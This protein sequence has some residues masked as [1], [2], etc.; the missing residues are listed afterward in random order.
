MNKNAYNTLKDLLG[1]ECG[2]GSDIIN[3]HAEN[4]DSTDLHTTAINI[5]SFEDISDEWKCRTTNLK[6]ASNNSQKTTFSI[7]YA[8]Q[9]AI[10]FDDEI[11]LNTLLNR[12]KITGKSNIH[13]KSLIKTA[14]KKKSWKCAASLYQSNEKQLLNDI[15]SCRDQCDESS[16]GDHDSNDCSLEQC[17]PP[18]LVSRFTSTK[19]FTHFLRADYNFYHFDENGC[20]VIHFL[21]LYG[22]DKGLSFLMKNLSCAF[23]GNVR[24]IKSKRQQPTTPLMTAV[25]NDYYQCIRLLNGYD[26]DD[27]YGIIMTAL[28]CAIDDGSVPCVMKILKRNEFQVKVDKKERQIIKQLMTTKDLNSKKCRKISKFLSNINI[29]FV[30]YAT[31]GNTFKIFQ[32]CGNSFSS[33]DENGWMLIH[34]LCKRGNFEGLKYQLYHINS[35]HCKQ[36]TKGGKNIPK[37]GL[38]IAIENKHTKCVKL[39]SKFDDPKNINWN[40]M[41]SYKAHKIAMSDIGIHIALDYQEDIEMSSVAFFGIVSY[42]CTKFLDSVICFFCFFVFCCCVLVRG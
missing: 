10:M 32:K 38:M 22:N 19:I 7:S 16:L 25:A 17:F 8:V 33:Y 26:K 13:S 29:E 35:K 31:N 21:C 14:M 11:L 9:I 15:K 34:Y 5:M 41:K 3:T 36:E 18:R 4:S 1:I 2:H 42:P 28:V 20:M 40:T 27:K 37:S 6:A 39:L 30:A 23:N 12:F 24:N